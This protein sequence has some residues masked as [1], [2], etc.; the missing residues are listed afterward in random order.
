MVVSNIQKQII[1]DIKNRMNNTFIIDDEDMS[2]IHFE[3][4]EMAD[5]LKMNVEDFHRKFLETK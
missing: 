1:Q 2:M 5:F 3:I 4:K